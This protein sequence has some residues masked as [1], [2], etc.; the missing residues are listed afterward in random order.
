MKNETRCAVK[1]SKTSW[2]RGQNFWPRENECNDGTS[3]N[4]CEFAMI[5]NKSY[6]LTYL[7]LLI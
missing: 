3:N 2:P 4:H 6:L 7:V 1:S 5:I